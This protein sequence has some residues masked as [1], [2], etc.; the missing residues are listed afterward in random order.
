MEGVIQ[1]QFQKME[2]KISSNQKEMND[3]QMKKLQN[4]TSQP[5]TFKRKG[6]E[7]QYKFNN[8]VKEKLDLADSYMKQKTEEG[9][10]KASSCITE[11]DEKRIIKAEARAAKKV[12]EQ[13]A[14][15]QSHRGGRFNPYR[16]G[17]DTD[18]TVTN[19][20]PRGPRRPGNC[21]R[22]RGLDTGR[23][24]AATL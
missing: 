11:Y 20:V 14:K 19:A 12:K 17:H 6:N 24:S 10:Q 16:G 18:S 22:C 9:H 7:A 21:Y 23:G 5:Y 4:I 1:G 13:K 8:D 15:K 3:I 2:A